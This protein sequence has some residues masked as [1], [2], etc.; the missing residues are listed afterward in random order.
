MPTLDRLATALI[1]ILGVAHTA[2]TPVFVRSLNPGALWFAGAGLALLFLGL[3][4]AARLLTPE[5]TRLRQLCLGANVLALLWIIL[6]IAV[7]P[8]PQAFVTGLAVLLAT[9]GA[10]RPARQAPR[11]SA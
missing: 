6:V 8:Q 2:L 10:S 3:F 9:V 4:N 7:L 11:Q 1:L 5:G